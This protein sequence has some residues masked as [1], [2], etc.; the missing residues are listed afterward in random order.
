MRG[1]LPYPGRA[2]PKINV[3]KPRA[4]AVQ[5]EEIA[6]AA[7]QA[8]G[9]SKKARRRQQLAA[10]AESDP[11]KQAHGAGAGEDAGQLAAATESAAA[12]PESGA[13]AGLAIGEAGQEPRAGE[14]AATDGD[15][16]YAAALAAPASESHAD[17]GG[18]EVSWSHRRRRRRGGPRFGCGGFHGS[19]HDH[20]HHN[21]GHSPAG[22]L[23]PQAPEAAP[24]AP[25][26]LAEPW[27]SAQTPVAA[28]VG[29]AEDSLT[30]AALQIGSP[31][32]GATRE[33]E[34]GGTATQS[35]APELPSPASSPAVAAPGGKRR[36]TRG[37][38][39]DDCFLV[40]P[41]TKV[42]CQTL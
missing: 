17:S 14:Q 34:S 29:G 35:A 27:S 41:L 28:E 25:Q 7:A 38:G 20:N 42:R 10:A 12:E 40:C 13:D 39:G 19:E 6:A 22:W 31:L 32:G 15:A 18:W 1:C 9:Q 21:S 37:R 2:W 26:P 33:A 3:V 16:E 11:G 36:V 5:E 23:S 30:L 4:L 24:A 8:K